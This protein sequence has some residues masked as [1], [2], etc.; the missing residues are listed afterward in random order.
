MSLRERLINAGV[1]V[2]S[3]GI[4]S[5]KEMLANNIVSSFDDMG[6]ANANPG[7]FSPEEITD[8]NNLVNTAAMSNDTDFEGKEETQ[9]DA[10]S[11]INTMND[12]ADDMVDISV[13]VE[14][15]ED[16][17]HHCHHPHEEEKA[18]H[19]LEFGES[20]LGRYVDK[21]LGGK[22]CE[23]YLI[24]FNESGE[25]P[26]K[27]TTRRNASGD[28]EIIGEDGKIASI[29]DTEEEADEW[30][31]EHNE[32]LAE[33]DY[34]GP[35]DWNPDTRI[36]ASNVLTT[37]KKEIGE[38]S[39]AL[40]VDQVY[41][42]NHND[43]YKVSQIDEKL[44]PKELKVETIVLKLGDNNVYYKDKMSDNYPLPQ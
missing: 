12:L 18:L 7:E 9:T 8:K 6:M 1:S 20:Y 2:L 4:D 13:D 41:D 38:G 28:Y 22:T 23:E 40:H 3:E 32:F 11:I 5:S 14:N 25:K 37:L 43:A 42:K 35:R 17:E 36:N 44:L 16:H 34:A 31:K 33:S 15:Q 10:S 27:Y 39:E 29:C 21:I 26:K 24:A 19:I 30:I